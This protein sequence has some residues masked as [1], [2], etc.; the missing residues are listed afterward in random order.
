MRES[1][2]AITIRGWIPLPKGDLVASAALL[3]NIADADQKH[4]AAAIV[5]M[6]TVDVDG[7]DVKQTSR[8][9]KD[10]PKPEGDDAP[11]PEFLRT[12]KSAA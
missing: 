5:A 9:K 2:F 12:K 6:M 1:G 3:N 8:Q 4:D 11:I 7:L 10:K